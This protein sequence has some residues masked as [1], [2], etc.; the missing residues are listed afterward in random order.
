MLQIIY[1]LCEDDGKSTWGYG[2]FTDNG[3]EELSL[4]DVLELLDNDQVDN[5]ELIRSRI[6]LLNI[7]SPLPKFRKSDYEP[8]DEDVSVYV[9]CKCKVN[10]EKGYLVVTPLCKLEFIDR[11]DL[12]SLCME[13]TVCNVYLK[14]LYNDNTYLWP[15]QY[16]MPFRNIGEIELT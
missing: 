16:N 2:V 11:F 4:E 8:L 7:N 15:I 6:K 10:G 13:G 14:L 1:E 5:A 9:V 3:V 12:V